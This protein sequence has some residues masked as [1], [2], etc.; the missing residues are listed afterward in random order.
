VVAPYRRGTHPWV[1]KRHAETRR[2][3]VA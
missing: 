1:S 3:R 2:K